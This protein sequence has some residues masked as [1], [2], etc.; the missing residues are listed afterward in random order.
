MCFDFGVFLKVVLFFVVWVV[1]VFGF[2]LLWCFFVVVGEYG[3]FFS[4]DGSGNP[5]LFGQ[6]CNGQQE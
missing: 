6:D 3:F 2:F 5:C 1:V 4:P